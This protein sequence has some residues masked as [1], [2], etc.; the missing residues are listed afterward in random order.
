MV[1]I[2][3][4]NYN[5]AQ[6]T[7]DC[8]NSVLKC[9]SHE[10]MIF[11]IDNG[12]EEGN[13]K[14]LDANFKDVHNVKILR[15][16]KNKGYVGG[17]NFG[18]E[19]ASIS[20]ADYYVIMNNDTI[21]D[22]FAISGLVNTSTK[23]NDEAIVAG[24]VY[25]FNK[26]DTIQYVGGI[27]RNKYLVLDYPHRNEKDIGQCEFET[28]RDMLDDILW[29]IPSKVFKVVGY[30]S[31]DFFLYAEQGDYARRAVNNGF[32]LIYTPN[33]K[34]WHKGSY[35]TGEGDRNAPYVNFWRSQ[36]GIIY[37]AKHLSNYL[38]W[39]YSFYLLIRLFIRLILSFIRK[40]IMENT[41]SEYASI[42]GV[43]NGILWK[44]NNKKNT[45]Y[46][47]FLK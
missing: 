45:G 16:E 3:T 24:K 7:T 35:T 1:H 38:F 47:P 46:N 20:E 18:L 28:E 31:N 39:T 26:P 41:K 36:G 5:H 34:I 25:H 8:V 21:I 13:Y 12:S 6:M 29:L 10:F 37:R 44:F 33:A 43:L 4:I 17:V 11:I 23:Y 19:Q 30:Y 15:L 40:P 14:K 2:I 9:S 27:F 22:K 42:R 32:K